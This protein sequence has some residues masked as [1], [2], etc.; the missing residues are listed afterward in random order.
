M[1]ECCFLACSLWLALLY[2]D[3]MYNYCAGNGAIFINQQS[4]PLPTDMTANQTG[5]GNPSVD[6]LFSGDYWLHQD[7]NK[8]NQD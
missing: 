3:N 5:V 7:G 6:F 8:A 1:E 4:R 2:S